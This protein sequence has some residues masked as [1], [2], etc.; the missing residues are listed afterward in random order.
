M[1]DQ[2]VEDVKDIG[3]TVDYTNMV[4]GSKWVDMF[5]QEMKNATDVDDAKMRA[6]KI[7]EAFE[8]SI[9]SHSRASKEVVKRLLFCS[10]STLNLLSLRVHPLFLTS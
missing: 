2:S 5:V 9:T 8:R 7:L 4:D 10:L 6:A 1:S 3:S